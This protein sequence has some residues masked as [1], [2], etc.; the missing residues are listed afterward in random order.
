MQN[1]YITELN[2]KDVP[3]RLRLRMPTQQFHSESFT[4]LDMYG[5]KSDPEVNVIPKI[6]RTGPLIIYML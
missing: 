1:K 3:D 5:C 6:N 2:W 4:K